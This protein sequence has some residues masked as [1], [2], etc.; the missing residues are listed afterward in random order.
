M[1][2]EGRPAFGAPAS[3][4]RDKLAGV[5]PVIATPFGEDG[6]P[7]VGDLRSVVAWLLKVGVDGVVFPG[8]ASEVDQLEAAE[9]G[10]LVAVVGSALGGCHAFVVGASAPAASAAAKFAQA[11]LEAGAA[12]AMIMAPRSLATDEAGLL[13]FY[14]EAAEPGIPIILQNAPPPAGAGLDI[15]LIARAVAAVPA[16]R[17][18]KEETMPCGQR[19][20]ALLAQAPPNLDGVFGGAGA[21]YLIDELARGAAGTMPACELADVHVALMH[22]WDT[23][24]RKRA[25]ALYSRSLPLLN[26]QAVF[27]MAMTKEVLRRRGVIRS[28]GLRASGPRLDAGDHAELTE[29]LAEAADILTPVLQDR[30]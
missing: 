4:S 6:R 26:F 30:D 5:F 24:D 1:R 12:A 27:R 21:R 15:A 17:Y 13:R 8:V 11:G 29:L 23:G 16:I 18:V 22:A 9:R 2:S 14:H 28:R 25:R 19:I 20:G 10:Q 7:D 3:S